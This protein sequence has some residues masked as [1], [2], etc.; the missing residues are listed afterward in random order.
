ME[1]GEA[2][3]VGM[4]L[5]VFHRLPQVQ[6]TWGTHRLPGGSMAKSRGEGRG[7]RTVT[8]HILGCAGIPGHN[9]VRSLIPAR[10]DGSD[11]LQSALLRLPWGNPAP[12]N[13][14]K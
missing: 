12:A 6:R 9:G 3:I 14:I 11:R 13:K 7:S 10:R 2:M 8:L 4:T 1:V 5:C